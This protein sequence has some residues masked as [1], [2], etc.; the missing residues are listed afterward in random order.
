M[1]LPYTEPLTPREPGER[2]IPRE[3]GEEAGAQE[4]VV[5][6][7]I[8]IASPEAAAELVDLG[9][10]LPPA[11]IRLEQLVERLGTALARD[12]RPHAVRVAARGSEIDQPRF[13][14]RYATRSA[15]CLSES[16]APKSGIEFGKPFSM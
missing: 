4:V 5:V 9:H 6:D 14:V 10:E 11:L 8:G 7:T 1:L 13:W 16:V 3:A 15:I 2:V 12:S